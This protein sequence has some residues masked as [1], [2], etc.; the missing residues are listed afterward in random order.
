MGED[1]LRELADELE[2]IMWETTDCSSY[3]RLKKIIEGLDEKYELY[4]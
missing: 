4:S 1:E 3:A 2:D